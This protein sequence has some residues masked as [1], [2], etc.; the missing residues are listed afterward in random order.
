MQPYTY[1][2]LDLE[3][4]GGRP[5]DAERAMRMHWKPASNWKPATIGERYLEMLAKKQERLALIDGSE[6][7]SIALRS[8]SEARVLHCLYLHAPNPQTGAMIEGFATQRDMLVALRALIDACVTPDTHLV[9][10]N[11]RDFDLPKLRM[12]YLR[13][14]LRLPLCL[15]SDEQPIFDTMQVWGR[16]FSANRDCFVSVADVCEELGIETHKDLVDGSQVDGLYAE[17]KFDT[18]IKY[19]L[20]DVLVEHEMF[21]RMTGQNSDVEGQRSKVEGGQPAKPAALPASPSPESSDPNLQPVGTIADLPP[22]E[23]PAKPKS[24]RKVE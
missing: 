17:G 10:H 24:K 5:E 22:V 15:A 14:G 23:P 20:L 16:R 21:R 1:L 18:I 4:K 2:T 8:D 7:I 11:I 13:E 9:G 19:N 3:T 6:V 12:A